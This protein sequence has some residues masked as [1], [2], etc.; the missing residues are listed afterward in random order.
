MTGCNP[1]WGC[2]LIIA[3]HMKAYGLEKNRHK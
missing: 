2:E 1:G 3:H